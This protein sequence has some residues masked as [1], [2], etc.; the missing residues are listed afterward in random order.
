MSAASLLIR[1]REGRRN[2]VSYSSLEA[3]SAATSSAAEWAADSKRLD[4]PLGGWRRPL[5]WTC[6]HD[7][8]ERRDHSGMGRIVL[9]QNSACPRELP[10]LERI[11]LPHRHSC[12]EGNARITPRSYP[13]LASS[14]IAMIEMF[15]RRSTSGAQPLASFSNDQ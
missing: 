15:R 1:R 12:C 8:D 3:F 13:P 2:I 5:R 9:R 11:D 4:P 14:P 7:A 6:R 10:Q